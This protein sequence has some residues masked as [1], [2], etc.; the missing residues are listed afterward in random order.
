[1]RARQ[2]ALGTRCAR[3]RAPDLQAPV[4]GAFFL[5]PRERPVNRP[6][7][8]ALR[9]ES[10]WTLTSIASS[11]CSR[12]TPSSR[13]PGAAS[14]TTR[15]W[16]RAS[17]AGSP[18]RRRRV[19]SAK[20][21]VAENQAARRAVEKDLAMIQARLSKFKDQLMEVKTNKE[22]TAMLKEIEVGAARGAH[23]EDEDPRADAR[24]RRP[25]GARRRRRRP[26]WR[27]DKG[28]IA[29]RA[30]ADRARRP[31]R[32][33]R[34]LEEAVGAARRSWRRRSRRRPR[35]LRHRARQAR[36]GGASE[37][38]GGL[39]QRLPRAAAAA[40]RQRA[41]AERDRI[42]QC[43][44]C[45]RILYIPAQPAAGARRPARRPT[46]DDRVHRR[47]VSRQPRARPA[48]ACGSRRA[49]ASL[50][51]ELHGSL[52]IADEQRRRVQRPAR[53]AR[54]GPSTTASTSL[55]IRS[56]SELL[57]KQMLGVYRVKNP[58][59][60][61]LYQQARLLA[62]RI[63]RV[64]FKH[65]RREFNKEAD[66][67]ANLA[68]DEAADR[69]SAVLASPDDRRDAARSRHRRAGRTANQL[70]V[71]GGAQPGLVD[72]VGPDARREQLVAVGRPEVEPQPAA[73]RP[74]ENHRS[75]SA[76]EAR[77]LER[78]HQVLAHLVAAGTDARAV[79]DDEVVGAGAE[80]ARAAPPRPPAA[81]P[82]RCRASRRARRRRPATGG[83]PSAAARSRPPGW[84][85]RPSGSSDTRMS[86]SGRRP[87]HRRPTCAA[88]TQA[89]ARRRVVAAH[90]D[91]AAPVHLVK[92]QQPVGERRRWSPPT[93]RPVGLLGRPAQPE[94]TRREEV[95]GHARAAAPT[96][97]P[98][99]R[100]RPSTGTRRARSLAA[101]QDHLGH[102]QRVGVR[103]GHHRRPAAHRLEP[104]RGARRAT[105]V[106]EGRP[107]APP[108]RGATGR[109]ASARCPAPSSPLP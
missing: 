85:G 73:L 8:P 55:E 84:R 48:T 24:G 103:D 27:R 2:D 53:R 28:V 10:P 4:S 54:A 87:R 52:G 75:T 31:T 58:G 37:V 3:A 29:A 39:L 108:R 90:D 45:Q 79:R 1:M 109:R 9:S 35:H 56:D 33:Q 61:P 19:E 23:L 26:S 93:A 106:A 12:P 74:R 105:A 95:I 104:P 6:G 77:R 5:P 67:L 88:A 66:R 7:L 81:A 62:H 20:A 89:V 68:M 59:L 65:V 15:R 72:V 78:L 30:A 46:A 64:T 47:R 97:A 43:E 82:R 83:R 36:D 22:Y 69:A 51:E 63:G 32:L 71:A 98:A 50:V 99:P 16:S 21:R 101:H 18:P 60:Q 14:P 91:R 44:S 25:G 42:F 107:A 94:L 70:R 96:A 11:A 49:T 17:T 80:L 100:A 102:R 13:T 40:G 92:P 86:A 41:P 38:E 57:V 76:A 34:E